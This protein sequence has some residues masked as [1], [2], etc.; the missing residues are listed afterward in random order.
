MLSLVT[1]TLIA[2]FLVAQVALAFEVA[3]Y[4]GQNSGY[5]ATPQTALKDYCD[6]NTADIVVVSFINKINPLN[7]NL[8]NICGTE[9]DSGLLHCPSVG[10]DIAYC[11]SQGKKVL[12]S[13]G[14][15]TGAKFASDKEATEFATNVWNKFGGGSD[16]ERPFDAA[17]VDGFD[18]DFE[19][20]DQTGTVAFG[21]TLRALYGKQSAKQYY[22]S[23]SPQCVYPDE[24]LNAYLTQVSLD[25]TFVQFYNNQ[26]KL[27]GDFNFKAWSDYVLKASPNKNN[28]LFVGLPGTPA[29]AP[30][31]GYVS[32]DTVEETVDSIKCDPHFGG[33]AVWDASSSF[34]GYAQG[35]RQILDT[36]DTEECRTTTSTTSKAATSTTSKATTAPTTAP[37]TQPAPTTPATIEPS[38]PYG[39]ST[40]TK[41]DIH[42]TVITITS[43]D[44][45][46]CTKVPVTTGLTTVT[47]LDTIYTTYCPLLDATATETALSTTLVTVTECDDNECTAKT[48]ET[49]APTETE[50]PETKA[51]QAPET[52]A[53]VSSS[54]SVAPVP[55]T[56]PANTASSSIPDTYTTLTSFLTE[57]KPAFTSPATNG[58]SPAAPTVITASANMATSV[59]GSLVL[60]GLSALAALF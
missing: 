27:D 56:A 37:T 33:L 4:W 34:S 54:P 22:L 31:G 13:V 11:Q 36:V 48:T 5:P 18:L 30:A 51:T 29:S 17:V 60:I 47:E 3:A 46:K 38:A 53:S 45:H 1:Q 41:T 40:S 28:K 44:D 25:Y 59:K 21:N 7:I 8:A 42:T 50:A 16:D 9:F 10:D 32:L 12:L 23:A 14:G 15:A 52:D 55:T 24:S 49:K 20:K 19:S 39:N 35:L 2:T 26:C 57:Q 58:S 6:S 43:C